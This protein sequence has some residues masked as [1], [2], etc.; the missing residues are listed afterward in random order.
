MTREEAFEDGFKQGFLIG[1]LEVKREIIIILM[2]KYRLDC[3]EACCQY[4]GF[5]ECDIARLMDYLPVSREKWRIT[6]QK[7]IEALSKCMK[8]ISQLENEVD[9]QKKKRSKKKDK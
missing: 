5:R 8:A 9:E 2:K 7:E 6:S 3:Y 4:L 1:Q